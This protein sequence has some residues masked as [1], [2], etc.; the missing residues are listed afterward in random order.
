MD[1]VQINPRTADLPD[2]E[3]LSAFQLAQLR[4][5]AR[6]IQQRFDLLA[7]SEAR[8]APT[9]LRTNAARKQEAQAAVLGGADDA[10]SVRRRSL[11]ESEAAPAAH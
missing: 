11:A 4:T 10:P 7:E 5:Q 1:G 8:T 2:T 9:V 6:P 3:N